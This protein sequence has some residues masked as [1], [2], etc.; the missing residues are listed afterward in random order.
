MK[1]RS[2]LAACCLTASALL[3]G[4]TGFAQVRNS[5]VV[6]H[7]AIESYLSAET[8][9]VAWLDV[10]QLQPQ[11]VADFLRQS[12]LGQLSDSK[13]QKI[14]TLRD[15]LVETGVGRLYWIGDMAQAL[16]RT[17]RW[18]I[19]SS[20][21]QATAVALRKVAGGLSV[22][23]QGSVVL[24]GSA[25]Q[26][27]RL[28]SPAATQPSAELHAALR[29]TR[30]TVGLVLVPPAHAFPAAAPALKE[31]LPQDEMYQDLIGNVANTRLLSLFGDLPPGNNELRLTVD[32]SSS[33]SD[34]AELLNK[35]LSSQSQSAL[36][37]WEATSSG[38]VLTTNS[39][40]EVDQLLLG[41]EALVSPAIRMRQANNLKQISLALHNYN[42]AYDRFPPQCLANAAGERLLSWRVLI[43]PYLGEQELYD[44]FR[45]D[46]P[47][48]SPHNLQ[49]AERI[50]D[51]FNSS[52]VESTQTRIVAPLTARS[53][54]GKPGALLTFRDITDGSSNTIWLVQ[55]RPEAAV[56]WTRP[57]DLI[58][59]E[60]M[61]L[62]SIFDDSMPGFWIAYADGSVHFLERKLLEPA[63]LLGLLTID[64]GEPA[65][66]P[67]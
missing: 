57:A 60:A 63:Q 35:L 54:F 26:F 12:D 40:H 33:A 17:P 11:A 14:S 47:W 1:F 29:A 59:D 6:D 23:V 24:I 30:G 43:L 52:G 7:S 4:L 37:Q 19:P 32:Q 48:N 67:R 13:V 15:Q 64:G 38:V 36:P 46:E 53:V 58:V 61:P 44:Q 22:E 28:K 55:A 31:W 3:Q 56:V 34:L 39:R 50:P 51:V 8:E 10:S 66:A 18:I 45:M 2:Q 62:E 42:A 16:S 27:D 25:E 20:N 9:V 65:V 41:L 49:L 21:P 5:P